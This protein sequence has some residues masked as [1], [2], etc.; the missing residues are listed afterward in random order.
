MEYFIGSVMTLVSVYF[1]NKLVSKNKAIKNN[2]KG[3]RFS[4]SYSHNLTKDLYPISHFLPS[5]PAREK[6][7][8]TKDFDSRST[9]VLYMDGLAWFI[10]KIDGMNALHV[11]EII[12]GGFDEE[13]VKRVDT[14]TMDD[15]ELKKTMFIVEKLTEGLS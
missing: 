10:K 5:F 7:Q 1:M 4:Q 8:A 12:D 2:I 9:R 15:V 14:M 6:T 13:S 3:L 11:A